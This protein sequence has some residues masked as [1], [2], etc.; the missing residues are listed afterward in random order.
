MKG[1]IMHCLGDLVKEKFG[2]D[3]WEEALEKAGLARRAFFIPSQNVEDAVVMK[4]VE[5][6]CGVLKIT[7]T[8]AADAF[9]SYWV[10]VYAPKLYMEFF[11]EAHS[12]KEFLS[13]MDTVH[14]K[15]TK[16]IPDAHPPRFEYEMKGDKTMILT[17]KSHRGLVD[18]CVGLIK[19]VG[20]YYKED[21]TVTKIGGNK[22]QI[23]FT[24]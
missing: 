19:G 22:I 18:F 16:N 3:K 24:R 10:T 5:A 4:T 8:Q 7:P 21:L 6:V 1:A 2:K 14:E 17:Y 13:K 20:Q 15:M 9:G 23:G 11:R 12:A